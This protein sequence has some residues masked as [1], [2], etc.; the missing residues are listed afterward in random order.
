MNATVSTAAV[1]AA[2]PVLAGS[3]PPLGPDP[4]FAAI[5]AHRRAYQ[6]FDC[7]DRDLARLEEAHPE[8]DDCAEIKLLYPVSRAAGPVFLTAASHEEIDRVTDDFLG[9][10]PIPGDEEF[11]RWRSKVERDRVQ[12]HA[13]FNAAKIAW[14]QA[15]DAAGITAKQEHWNQIEQAERDTAMALIEA[16][17]TTLAGV[18]AKILYVRERTANY[19]IV[20]PAERIAFLLSLEASLAGMVAA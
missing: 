14:E 2:M 12:H 4:I 7:A 1:A 9:V 6:A 11:A 8:I 18:A 17:P 15:R 3:V 19:F 16:V 13:D 5:D 10:I 20:I